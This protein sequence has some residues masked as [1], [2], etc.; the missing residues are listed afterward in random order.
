VLGPLVERRF[1][2]VFGTR[3]SEREAPAA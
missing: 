3:L 1:E 2:E